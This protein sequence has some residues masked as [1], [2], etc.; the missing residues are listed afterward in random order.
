MK[1][2]VV[3]QENIQEIF[4]Q[5][6]KQFSVPGVNPLQERFIYTENLPEAINIS[7]KHA[8]YSMYVEEKGEPVA[9]EMRYLYF[10]ESN[11]TLENE[12]FEK[13]KK[14]ISFKLGDKGNLSTIETCD[15]VYFNKTGIF[16]KKKE[17]ISDGIYGFNIW[18]FF[19]EHGNNGFLQNQSQR[20]PHALFD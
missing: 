7:E 20:H 8:S 13:N 4:E 14:F 18:K 10:S 1:K 2:I 3:S 11:F 12:Y 5:F 16:I 15:V 19:S 9:S 17:P 6:K